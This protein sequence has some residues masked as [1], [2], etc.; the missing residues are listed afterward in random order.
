LL[1]IGGQLASNLF[2]KVNANLI[3]YRRFVIELTFE[4]FC[5]LEIKGQPASKNAENS[6]RYSTCNS[7]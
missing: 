6:A 5:L 3:V 7:K 4:N 2:L 1:E